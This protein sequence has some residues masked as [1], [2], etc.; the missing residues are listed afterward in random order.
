MKVISEFF[1]PK[2]EVKIGEYVFNKGIECEVVS[3]QDLYFDWAKVKFTHKFNQKFTFKKYDPIKVLFGYDN[4]LKEIF[5]GYLAKS[6][7]S[8]NEVI[9]KDSM[10]LLEQTKVTNTFLDVTPQELIG[11]CL[12]KAGMHKYKLSEQYYQR[13]K[14]VP[15]YEKNIISIFNEINTNWN[16]NNKFFFQNNTFYWGCEPEQDKKYKFEY[17]KNIIELKKTNIEWELS[18]VSVP[19]IKHSD[20][21]YVEHPHISGDFKVKRIIFTTD[22]D[23]FIRTKIYF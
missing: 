21:I 16:I 17:A 13:K 19:F 23:G 10:L 18:T 4:D 9:F 6:G 15:V 20:V 1:Y 11:Y 7:E 8:K 3:S 22:A 12:E 2:I 14:Q 5:S